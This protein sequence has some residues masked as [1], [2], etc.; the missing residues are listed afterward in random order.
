MKKDFDTW[1]KRKKEIDV[2]IVRDSIFFREAEVWWIH[3]GLRPL[4]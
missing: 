1:N 4:P 3:I 2:R